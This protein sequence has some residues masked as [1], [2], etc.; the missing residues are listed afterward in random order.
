MVSR[1]SKRSPLL[2]PALV[3]V[4]VVVALVG[5]EALSRGPSF[6]PQANQAPSGGLA[7]S[8]LP[9]NS[10]GSLCGTFFPA[11]LSGTKGGSSANGSSTSQVI[12]FYLPAGS[13]GT[14]C[15]SYEEFNSTRSIPPL[16]KVTAFSGGALS[17]SVTSGDGGYAVN[18]SSPA[19]GVTA[20]MSIQ[21][22]TYPKNGTTYLIGEYTF[23]ASPRT[24]GIFALKYSGECPPWIP[25]A[26][27]YNATSAQ[28]AIDSGYQVFLQPAGC[29]GTIGPVLG[30][31]DGTVVGVGG[32]MGLGY[33]A[34]GGRT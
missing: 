30:F 19:A 16:P 3:A 10:T 13:S 14:V 1:R 6:N 24:Q 17:V 32:S 2:L 15:V 7:P 11:G 21:Y 29:T 33:I 12:V 9:I 5:V 34:S 18:S 20:G 23:T 22:L 27:G 26:V 31:G 4:V 25:M 8:G 28:K